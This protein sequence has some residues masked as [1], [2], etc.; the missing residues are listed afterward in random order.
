MA[1]IPDTEIDRLKTEISLERLVRSRGVELRRHGAD[2]IGLCPFH[3]D[4]EPSL[5]ITPAKNLWHCLGACQWNAGALVA[6]DDHHALAVAVGGEAEEDLA[7]L[8]VHEDVAGD[9][10]DGSGDDGLLTAREAG[11]GGERPALLA[12]LDDIHVRRDGQA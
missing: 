10:G 9:L 7:L 4:Q 11:N 12:S 3:N 8:G 2:L 6:G 5:V 1:R